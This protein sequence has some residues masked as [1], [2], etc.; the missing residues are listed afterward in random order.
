M[1]KVLFSVLFIAMVA[2]MI[3]AGTWAYFSDL[4][5][6]YDNCFTAGSLDLKV[7]GFDDPNVLTYFEIECIAP[8]DSGKANVTLTNAGCV[9]GYGDI[10]FIMT[11]NS[12]N[13]FTEPEDDVVPPNDD[14]W[15]GT[16]EGDLCDVL[17]LTV[18][19]DTDRDGSYDETIFAGYTMCGVDC[20]N[21]DLGPIPGTDFL[22]DNWIELEISW[23]VPTTVGNIIQTDK[24]CG[25]IE[26]SLH[27]NPITSETFDLEVTSVGC[28][29]IFVGAPINDTVAAG[30]TET[31]TG[32][33]EGTTISVNAQDSDVCCDF[34]SWAGDINSAAG[35]NPN[36]VTMD[37]NKSVTATCT[38]ASYDLT[39]N[40]SA[41][42]CSVDVGAPVS[43]TVAAYTTQTFTVPC[44]AGSPA[45]VTLDANDGSGCVF[46]D[47]SGDTADD[48]QSTTVTMDEDQ[49]VTAECE[50][51]T[52]VLTVISNGCCPIDVS[53]DASGT[54]PADDQLTFP[55]LNYGEEV[56]VAADST[57]PCCDFVSW[58]DGGAQSHLI[59]ITGD[60]TVTATCTEDTSSLTVD[61]TLSCCDVNVGAPVSATVSA[62]TTTTF[63]N[64][65]CGTTVSLA[66]VEV[67]PDCCDFVDWS[68]P[69]G[70][71][72]SATTD[73]D[74]GHDD[75]TVTAN[76]DPVPDADLYV[77]SIGCCFVEVYED[78]QLVY[79]LDP[80]ESWS[81]LGLPCCTDVD[82]VAVPP[83]PL[84]GCDDIELDGVS[85]GCDTGYVHMDGNDHTFDVTCSEL[86]CPAP[87]PCCWCIYLTEWWVCDVVG[88]PPCVDPPVV[89]PDN[90][91]YFALHVV[92][93]LDENHVEA[94][95]D[96]FPGGGMHIIPPPS[97][98]QEL[99]AYAGPM[100]NGYGVAEWSPLN[101]GWGAGKVGVL[102]YNSIL[103]K[104]YATGLGYWNSNGAPFTDQLIN[105]KTRF[106]VI[107]PL[108]A[109][110]LY[111][112]TL[113]VIPMVG[114]IGW[115]YA[116][117][118]TW[119]S[120]GMS[121]ITA[122][123][124]SVTTVS[125]TATV[126]CSPLFPSGI[127][128]YVVDAYSW[129]DADGVDDDLDGQVDEDPM[130]FYDDDG[131]GTVDEDGGDGMPFTELDVMAMSSQE[132]RN[133]AYGC[134]I[135]KWTMPGALYQ[136][137]EHQCLIWECFE[138]PYPVTEPVWP[139]P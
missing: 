116:V 58:S 119:A 52:Y 109:I 123:S 89:A 113:G 27:Q 55:G 91:E 94:V 2:S 120:V 108:G 107:T 64:I 71:A 44:D 72:A 59:T 25:D 38:N 65:D 16:A 34:D 56:T 114:N 3:G 6:S 87:E 48:N 78:S 122:P 138:P 102:R 81:D 95:G 85:I 137:W 74:V 124:A 101:A 110:T 10:H 112:G 90:V 39:V 63:P 67:T 19:A 98:H 73:V 42:C 128:C 17:E 47:W 134:V 1:K 8:G 35:Q 60:D 14:S 93:W 22:P 37:A 127:E 51:S 82:I 50:T 103:T 30:A 117:G 80:G 133:N 130:N 18:K 129:A 97:Y 62:G 86:E 45:V 77:N 121:S 36:S 83:P 139:L 9:D 31:F 104:V 69:V 88:T 43:Q 75:V 132:Y 118:N 23:F 84:C 76:C 49:T 7:D 79:T 20:I 105:W 15:D 53:G 125:G 40:Q 24:C 26:F 12:D 100:P 106:D 54:V 126:D 11:E 32:I 41:D 4:E 70:N 61:Q 92:E 96:P 131:D 46:N 111:S 5:T 29:P 68:G 57:D 99:V 28:C 135:E 136:G 33:M 115:P 13:G 66:A 21:W